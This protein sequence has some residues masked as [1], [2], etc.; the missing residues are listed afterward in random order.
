ML[1]RGFGDGFDQYTENH[2]G[3]LTASGSEWGGAEFRIALRL[4][5]ERGAG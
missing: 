5:N 1:S 3:T 4:E 2:G